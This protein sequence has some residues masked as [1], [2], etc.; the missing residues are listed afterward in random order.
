MKNLVLNK[1]L[2]NLEEAGSIFINQIVY[3]LKRLNVDVTTLS[4]GEAFFDLPLFDFQKLDLTKSNH[5]S[6]SQG[7][8][9]LRKKIARYY[10]ETQGGKVN[11]Q[12]EILIS[13]GSKCLVFMVMLALL[14]KK[15]EVITFEPAWLS[16]FGQAEILG[17]KI[18][19]LP[20]NRDI[21]DL[22]L[23]IFKNAKLIIL[24]NPNN[25]G[26]FVYS[27]RFIKKL[28]DICLKNN[29]W[30]LVD[31]AYSDFSDN[32]F[33]SSLL[34]SSKKKN[35]IIINSLSKSFGI[36]GW[37]IGYIISNSKLI[38]VILKINQH[39]ITCAPTILLQYCTEYFDKIR[40]IT[41]K[42]IKKLSE[43]RK[44]IC[45]MLNNLGIKYL[46]G[47]STF[48]I[49]IDIS[50]YKSSSENF[51]LDLLLNDYV[52]AIPGSVYGKST[53]KFIRIS[54]GTES[55]E[56]IYEALV[57]LKKKID[58]P[59]PVLNFKNK[60]KKIKDDLKKSL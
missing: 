10:F 7:L 37:R 28:Y 47:N 12:N 32:S 58:T 43:K 13:A 45:K 3:D 39:I 53:E 60:L 27:K 9:E 6:D 19:S 50:D 57:M 34:L 15:D 5:Y 44:K 16:Y 22:N 2:E 23:D 41:S 59:K 26:G 42:E 8:P 33:Y 29:I 17:I 20:Y 51:C 30:L 56:R 55:E 4:L 54:I 1:N 14:N 31:E 46:Q 24:N 21:D 36:S 40:S 25:P 11:P 38:D 18:K 35:V 52:A 49:F 48:Y